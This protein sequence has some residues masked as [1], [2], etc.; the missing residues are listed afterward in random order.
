MIR[1]VRL[2][3]CDDM[4]GD[5]SPQDKKDLDKF[6][7][8]FALKVKKQLFVRHRVWSW[9]EIRPRFTFVFVFSDRP[10]DSPSPPRR[11]DLHA[12]VLVAHRLRLGKAAFVFDVQ[13]GWKTVK[14][15]FFIPSSLIWPSKTSQRSLMRP[16]RRWPVSCRASAG[17][18]ASRSP[19][20][21][22]RLERL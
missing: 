5:L 22:Q 20:K 13:R 9:M 19:W 15:L 8:F 10:G 12:L 2:Q 16:R 11:E 7:K 3:V 1:L 17:P 14:L 4:D 18:C 21:R 6:I